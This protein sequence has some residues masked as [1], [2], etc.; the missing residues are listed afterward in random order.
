MLTPLL[1]HRDSFSELRGLFNQMDEMFR[2]I[3]R[4]LLGDGGEGW[5]PAEL[6]DDG[7]ALVLRMD[8]PG[9]TERDLTIEATQHGVTVRGE[10]KLHVP[11]G[12]NTHRR[13]R[14]AQAFTR[15]FSLPCRIDLEQCNAKVKHGVLSLRMAKLPEERPK[16]VAVSSG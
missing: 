8:V 4:P 13:E 3:D 15:S 16:Q 12:Y 10:R 9:M 6:R 11:E 5:L 7:E 14:R 1:T 2:G